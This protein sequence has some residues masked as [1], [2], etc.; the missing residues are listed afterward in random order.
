MSRR[1]ES[2]RIIQGAG[3][4][5]A[6]RLSSHYP[7]SPTPQERPEGSHPMTQGAGTDIAS[8]E[9]GPLPTEPDSAGGVHCEAG[10]GLA[11]GVKLRQGARDP[12]DQ[13][14]SCS[15]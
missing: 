11:V 15:K 12:H 9:I 10:R 5:T 14:R 4:D 13:A 1:P 6:R 7:Q 3:K 8:E 2:H